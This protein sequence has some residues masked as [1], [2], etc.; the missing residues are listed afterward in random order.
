L[1]FCLGSTSGGDSTIAGDADEARLSH[2]DD[3]DDDDEVGYDND[4]VDDE[5]GH[6]CDEAMTKETVCTDELTRSQNSNGEEEEEMKTF[7]TDDEDD[8]RNTLYAD[9]PSTPGK[10]ERNESPDMEKAHSSS[11]KQ[12]VAKDVQESPILR[13][14]DGAF[15]ESLGSSVA[16]LESFVASVIAADR[17]R[18]VPFREPYVSQSPQAPTRSVPLAPHPA[19]ASRSR[20]SKVVKTTPRSSLKS[21]TSVSQTGTGGRVSRPARGPAQIIIPPS[22]ITPPLTGQATL[23]Q[24]LDLSTKSRRESQYLCPDVAS[25]G[26]SS[27]LSL[28]R[29]FGKSSTIFDRIG[30][31]AWTAPYCATALRLGVQSLA[32]GGGLGLMSPPS[33]STSR[34]LVSGRPVKERETAAY[35]PVAGQQPPLM[36]SGGTA[37]DVAALLP[38]AQPPESKRTTT[39]SSSTSS[40]ISSS[41]HVH[42]NLQCGCGASMDSLFA[43][44]VCRI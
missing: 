10:L 2:D 16:R 12:S 24:P 22:F 8:E 5:I 31:K 28:E 18:P 13:E 21:P 32:F 1:C 15:A 7:S 26:P 23:D 25:A 42:T 17:K 40:A 38:W 36:S 35:P 33:P 44:M 37:T 30:T 19:Q 14:P 20:H 6:S 43:L 3:D 4:E 34:R 27:L 41:S 11:D 29:Q 9:V 39:T